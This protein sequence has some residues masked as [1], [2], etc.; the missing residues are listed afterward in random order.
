MDVATLQ[1]KV[2]TDGVKQASN[3][4]DKLSNNSNKS[5]K[6]VN[7]LTSS[8]TGLKSTLAALGVFAVARDISNVSLE[9]DRMQ[10]SLKVATGSTELAREEMQFLSSE[11]ERLGINLLS[12]GKGYAQLSAAAQGTAVS[13]AQVRDIFTAVSEASITLGLSA[14]DANG[15][16]RALTQIMSK[17]TVQAEELR[18]Q[19]GERIPGAFQIAARSMGVT[20][21][22]L[23][24]MLEQGMVLSDDFLPAFADEVQRTFGEAVPD[25]IKS[26]QAEFNRFANQ[27]DE[28]KRQVGETLNRTLSESAGLISELI[29]SVNVF[30]RRMALTNR[31]LKEVDEGILSN[32][33]AAKLW[34]MSISEA[35][36][37]IDK[38]NDSLNSLAPASIFT[39]HAE[40]MGVT[41][42][43]ANKQR[44]ATAELISIS[45]QEIDVIKRKIPEL[46]K[47][48]NAWNTYLNTLKNKYSSTMQEILSQESSLRTMQLDNADLI[49]GVENKNLSPRKKYHAEIRAL[50]EKEA[51]ASG[52]EG[53]E[54]I[55]M[56]KQINAEWA[57]L[58]NA[59]EDNGETVV[60]QRQAT[61]T[62]LDSMRENAALMEEE[63]QKI[64]DS[65]KESLEATGESISVAE[66]KINSY[67]GE[68]QSLKE[69]TDLVSKSLVIDV[70]TDEAT[71]KIKSLTA[72]IKNLNAAMNQES[73]YEQPPEN[74]FAG[75]GYT[76]RGGKYEPAG[77]VHKGEVVFSQADVKRHGGVAAVESMRLRGYADGGEV[78][79]R[80]AFMERLGQGSSVSQSANNTL[81]SIERKWN[82]IE[83]LSEWENTKTQYQLS[84][85]FHIGGAGA[86][87]ISMYIN[88]KLRD[89]EK[90]E[91]AESYDRVKGFADGGVVGGA[92]TNNNFSITIN[93]PNSNADSLARQLVPSIK[94]YQ[95]RSL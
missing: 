46:N 8:F 53:Q 57:S 13:Q 35:E 19:L 7:S 25:A 1:V 56:L 31:I 20:T 60:S 51:I 84:D 28:F 14:D 74:G 66:E 50:E 45:E 16:I 69:Q 62:A 30:G 73:V 42:N 48:S 6:S 71:K 54:K 82:A 87:Q 2:K 37:E 91:R 72:E 95:G 68:L 21:E 94:R 9:F 85:G 59:V 36:R 15:A 11:A 80:S 10:R 65:G 88:R 40:V 64:I 83:T 81:D 49:R 92:T 90:T 27:L 67:K 23:N 32:E 24:K 55:N 70:D 12:S 38:L 75:G 26:S 76:G 44:A 79:G 47:T 61:G 39:E 86:N 78:E 89:K 43:A 52:L 3:D 17:G 22:E 58:S 63:Q 41:A 93:T 77:I 29:E 33:E 5:S 4:L 18:G 34:K